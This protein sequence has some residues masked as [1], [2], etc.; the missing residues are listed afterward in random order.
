[1]RGPASWTETLPAL[2]RPAPRLGEHTCEVLE[3][4]GYPPEGA[5]RIAELHR[6]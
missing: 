4:I 6:L 2:R 3:E 1:M 5:E